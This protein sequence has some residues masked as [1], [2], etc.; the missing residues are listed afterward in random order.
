[1]SARA[2]ADA[3]IAGLAS[4]DFILAN[5]ANPDMV[6]HTGK[7]EPTI[8]A[9]EHVDEQIGRILAA[10]PKDATVIITADHGNCELMWDAAGAC[11]HTSHTT[12]PVPCWVMPPA[13]LREGGSLADVAPTICQRLGLAAPTTWTGRS[14]LT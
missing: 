9:I 1:M 2:V 7:L 3:V 11:P 6:G 14:L 13:A 4:H 5:F 10:A 8:R 12:S